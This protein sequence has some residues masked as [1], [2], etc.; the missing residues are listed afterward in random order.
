MVSAAFRACPACGTRNKLT[1]DACAQC[2]ESLAEVAVSQPGADARPTAS[3]RPQPEAGGGLHIPVGGLLQLA[4]LAAA[5]W[6]FFAYRSQ[7]P[8]A[9]SPDVFTIG[10]LPPST[11]PRPVRAPV[12]AWVATFNRGR[13]LL[14]Q[15]KAEEAVAYLAEAVAAAP[16]EALYRD[17][18]GKALWQ[19][20]ARDAALRE[21]DTAIALSPS[22]VEY[23]KDRARA[24]VALDRREEAEGDYAGAL[25][26]QP[27][28]VE[29]LQGLAWLRTERGDSAAAVE[30]LQR[31]VQLRPADP[32]LV[33]Y[34]AY[35]LEKSGRLDE[36]EGVYARLLAGYPDA[37]MTRSRLATT[38]VAQNRP[39]EALRVLRQG[40][41]SGR[42]TPPPCTARSVGCWNARGTSRT[43]SPPIA[44]TPGSPPTPGTPRTTRRARPRSSGGFSRSRRRT[45]SP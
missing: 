38:L 7:P 15:G 17:Y 36:A 43:R 33:Q 13:L 25:E 27:D 32:T 5:L 22:S 24:Y 19:T 45:T 1:W 18:Y 30:L 40:H 20:G 26:A 14:L 31:A 35:A 44:P 8:A 21:Y 39:E 28:D 34:Y 3:A 29:S 4:A 9:P 11:P 23:W 12:P 16:D 2:G 42:P 37:A 6:F 10:T 41:R